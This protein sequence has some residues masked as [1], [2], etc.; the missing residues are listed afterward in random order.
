MK[1]GVLHADFRI[2]DGFDWEGGK[3]DINNGIFPMKSVARRHDMV[4]NRVEN[5]METWNQEGV[6]KADMC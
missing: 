5:I 1:R 4:F 6:V 3:G 2:C